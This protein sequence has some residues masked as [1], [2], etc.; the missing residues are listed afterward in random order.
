MDFRVFADNSTYIV[1]IFDER[2]NCLYAN[3]AMEEATGLS[4]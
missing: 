2:M 3:P 1:V 4:A